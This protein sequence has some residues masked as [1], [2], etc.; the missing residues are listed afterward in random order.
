MT[1]TKEVICDYC[2][3]PAELRGARWS[4]APC[5]ASVGVHKQSIPTATR[6][7]R[8][9]YVPLGRLENEELRA[10]KMEA[11]NLFDPLWKR[12]KRLI[13]PG[14]GEHWTKNQ[15]RKWAYAQ[16][17]GEMGMTRK[18]CHLGL[19]DVAECRR[20]VDACRRVAAAQGWTSK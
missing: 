13:D 15:A 4:C 2:R 16:L 12:R 6:C 3:Q 1:T 11:K 18:E 20:A 5:G 17:A 7:P 14:T 8:W 10:A 9:A 19:F